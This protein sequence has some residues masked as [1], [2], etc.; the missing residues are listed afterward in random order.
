VGALI[1]PRDEVQ[2]AA[3]LGQLLAAFRGGELP[4]RPAPVGIERYHRRE[5]AGEFAAVFRAAQGWARA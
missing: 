4:P 2:I 5:L 3:Y 1:G